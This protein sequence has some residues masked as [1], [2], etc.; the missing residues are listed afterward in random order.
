MNA[1]QITFAWGFFGSIAADFM[2]LR[3]ASENARAGLPSL[4]KQPRFYFIA[5]GTALI[6]GGVAVV[7]GAD[8]P[9]LAFQIGVTAPFVVQSISK[10][11]PVLPG[12]G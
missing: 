8:K 4:Y 3:H 11:P 1:W 7:E 10:K 2:R 9:L 12:G 6:A 5:F